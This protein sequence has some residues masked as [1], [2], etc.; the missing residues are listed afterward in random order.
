M[1]IGQFT[2]YQHTVRRKRQSNLSIKQSSWSSVS[3][4]E[5][6]LQGITT[7]SVSCLTSYTMPSLTLLVDSPKTYRRTQADRKKLMAR[8]AT[9][10]WLSEQLKGSSYIMI[11]DCRPF[12]EFS[13]SHIQGAINLTIPSLMLRRL[14]KGNNFSIPSLITSEEGKENFKK[15]LPMA[16]CVVLYDSSTKDVSSVGHNSALGVVIKKLS[17]ECSAT[18]IRLLEG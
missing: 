16:S 4:G 7:N 11:L 2:K 8:G 12:G 14:K 13:R 18:N 5:L 6:E 15:N 10:G 17:E 3:N 1:L 9:V